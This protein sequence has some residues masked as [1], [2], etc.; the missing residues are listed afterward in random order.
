MSEDDEIKE[1]KEEVSELKKLIKQ[2]TKAKSGLYNSKDREHTS[3]HKMETGSNLERKTDKGINDENSSVDKNHFKKSLRPELKHG[4]KPVNN[5][6]SPEPTTPPDQPVRHRRFIG[7]EKKSNIHRSRSNIDFD[8]DFA[9]I[10]ES[11]D[12]TIKSVEII[13]EKGLTIADNI[14]KTITNKI[15]KGIDTKI[16]K[17]QDMPD[18]SKKEYEKL[19][20]D[21]EK[22]RDEMEKQEAEVNRIT[23]ELT[24][25]REDLLNARIDLDKATL[26]GND[27]EKMKAEQKL[28]AAEKKLDQTSAELNTTEYQLR[29]TKRTFHRLQKKLQRKRFGFYSPQG[30]ES[31]H[32]AW[33]WDETISEYMENVLSSIA[34][35]IESSLKS[36]VIGGKRIYKEISKPITSSSIL[37]SIDEL[38][39]ETLEEFVET[40]AE[41][42]SSVSDK[43]R[44]LVLKIL[45]N[46]P[47]YQKELSA[48]TDLKGGSFKHHTDILQDAGLITQ[49][50][51]RGRYIITQLGIETLK[52]AE[53]IY[54][55]DK[56]L[57]KSKED[58][59]S[60]EINIE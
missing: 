29:Q 35:N 39:D 3:E 56:S 38:T 26:V 47:E 20:E 28:L 8:I 4:K 5:S 24:K 34:K 40:A 45:E 41:I 9:K 13:S 19:R 37:S 58:D 7:E 32:A 48:K 25:G 33:K 11:I 21:L 27:K 15:Q 46:G 36:A 30:Q 14:A 10:A 43:K 2:L 57:K 23:Y 52:L 31:S 16:L 22:L 1:L 50:A 18:I 44:L 6:K 60:F 53:M 49:E 17:L 12:K 55:R 51:V 59:E 42:L 54:I